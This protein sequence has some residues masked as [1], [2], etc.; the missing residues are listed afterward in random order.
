MP[1]ATV[2]FVIVLMLLLF[3]VIFIV[4]IV[5]DLVIG[6]VIAVTVAT[7]ADISVAAVTLQFQKNFR[8][9]NYGRYHIMNYSSLLGTTL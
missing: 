7:V 6:V 2:A 1:A 8:Q 9:S 3:T 4:V 5:A